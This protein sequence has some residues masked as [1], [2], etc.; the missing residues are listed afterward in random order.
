MP[1][2]PGVGHECKAYYNSATYATPTWVEIDEAIDVGIVEF[3]TTMIEIMTRKSQWAANR[4]GRTRLAVE[5]S[6]LYRANSTVFNFLRAAKFA[7]TAVDFSFMDGAIATA[8]SEGLRMWGYLAEFPIN[9]ALEEAV[10]LDTIRI[11]HGLVLA[12]GVRQEPTWTIVT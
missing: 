1:A 2:S 6:Y 7:N 3:S 12:S 4:P 8:G 9:Q 11:A 10:V 5:A